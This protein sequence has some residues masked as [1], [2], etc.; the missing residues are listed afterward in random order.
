MK[1]AEEILKEKC[2]ENKV[3]ITSNEYHTVLKAMEEYRNQPLPEQTE[4]K[5]TDCQKV[6]LLE[7]NGEITV[8]YCSRYGHP[9]WNPPQNPDATPFVNKEAYMIKRER[10]VE[11]VN[12]LKYKIKSGAYTPES[13]CDN[14]D[15]FRDE[16][17]ALPKYAQSHQV[18]MPGDELLKT[19]IVEYVKNKYYP[20]ARSKS[21]AFNLIYY[22]IKSQI[23]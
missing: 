6:T 11:I 10:V 21:E 4:Y 9:L 18:E 14:L 22:F 15:T 7:D 3:Y 1:T 12:V 16:I 13:L 20:I 2:I 8:G 5:C 17:T 19:Q 23:K